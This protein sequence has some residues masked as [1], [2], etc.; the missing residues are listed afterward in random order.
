M[1]G[2]KVEGKQGQVMEGILKGQVQGQHGGGV[3]S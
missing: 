2:N 3:S 1:V